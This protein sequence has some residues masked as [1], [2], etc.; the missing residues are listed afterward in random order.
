VI[1]KPKTTPASNF[2]PT[3]KWNTTTAMSARHHAVKSTCRWAGRTENSRENRDAK[4]SKSALTIA[5][6]VYTENRLTT[7]LAM[8]AP[9]A[10][11]EKK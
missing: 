5:Q 3:Y 2:F 7:D 11:E 9:R 10:K 4:L 8:A 6:F 1:A